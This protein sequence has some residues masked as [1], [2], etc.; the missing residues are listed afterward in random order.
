M[1]ASMCASAGI[2]CRTQETLDDGAMPL[3]WAAALRGHP[4]AGWQAE[5]RARGSNVMPVL[6]TCPCEG[7][8]I[9]FPSLFLTSCS[10]ELDLSP[11]NQAVIVCTCQPSSFFTFVLA[12]K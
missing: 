6:A 12:P 11:R 7:L 2:K 4:G 8:K 3:G 1:S 10:L 9:C 5:G